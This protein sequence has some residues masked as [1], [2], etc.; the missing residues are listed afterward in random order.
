MRQKKLKTVLSAVTLTLTSTVVVLFLSGCVTAGNREYRAGERDYNAG[1][2]MSAAENAVS[3]LQINDEH[4]EALSLLRRALPRATEQIESQISQLEGATEGF[5]Y[6]R[7]AP[8]YQ[9]LLK[10]HGDVA[11]LRVGISTEDYDGRLQEARQ[12]A[13][14]G[15]YQAGQAALA[16][17]GFENAR[18]ALG[19]FNA[20]SNWAGEY[21]DTA[22]LIAQ[23]ADASMARLYVYVNDAQGALAD[24]LARNLMAEDRLAQ[25][26]ELIPPGTL[27]AGPGRDA[28]AVLAAAAGRGVDLL[29]FVEVGQVSTEQ[30]GLQE[31]AKQLIGGG[32]GFEV[33]AN[34]AVGTSGRWQIYDVARRTVRQ[35]DSFQV[36]LGE[37]LRFQYLPGSGDTD[38]VFFEDV[39]YRD[40]A[41]VELPNF[42]LISD[43]RAMTRSVDFVNANSNRPDVLA[44][45]SFTELSERLEGITL[46]KDVYVLTANEGRYIAVS[47]QSPPVYARVHEFVEKSNAII[48][49]ISANVEQNMADRVSQAQSAVPS[50]VEET[51]RRAVLAPLLQ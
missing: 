6:E 22:A 9:Q 36:R 42:S 8:L 1:N 49:S 24:S 43:T 11:A 48:A 2:Y 17:G 16:A 38:S 29:L 14:E 23:A 7:I 47:M 37:S 33:T 4:E 3:A 31:T 39:R 25:V 35:E 41:Y 27:G 51:V 5:P 12:A 18:V 21:K 19:H 32:Q 40:V 26:T 34:Y 15:R 50:R 44:T 46:F 30:Q 13:A 28:S 20:V 45:L 10:L